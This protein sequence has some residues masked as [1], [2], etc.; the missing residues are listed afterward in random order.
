[1]L[2]LFSSPHGLGFMPSLAYASLKRRICMTKFIQKICV[3]ICVNLWIIFLCFS[4]NAQTKLTS[5]VLLIPLDDRPPCL[6]FPVKMGLIGDVEVVTPPRNL[7]GRFTE[8]GKSD[9]II[10]W[11]KTQNLK[12]FD[13]AIV[14]L[15][16]LSYGGLVA[17]REYET[18]ES[19]ALKRADFIRELRKS[20]PKM[21]IYGS[22]VIM[23]LAPTGNVVNESY[24]ANLAKWAEISV[25]ESK[26]AETLELEKKIPAE[27]L[28]KYKKA[29]QRDLKLN[30]YAVELARDRVIDYLILSQDDAKPNGV[31]V[32]DREQLIDYVKSNNLSEKVAV[33]PGA[34][35]VSMLLLARSM[36]TKYKYRPKIKAIYSDEKIADQFMPYEDRPLRKTVSFHIKAVGATEVTEEKDADILFYVFVSRFESGK[37]ENFV[38]EITKNIESDKRIILADVDPKG[39][40]QGADIRFTEEM[41]NL[42]FGRLAGY[43]SWNT[44]GNTIG[45]ALPHGIMFSSIQLK[46][47]FQKRN[48]SMYPKEVVQR[49]R[50]LS[51]VS[52]AQTWFLLNRLLDDYVYHSIVRP[53][54]ITFATDKTWNVFRFDSEQTKA[55]EEFS[56]PKI[57]E[58]IWQNLN[59]ISPIHIPFASQSVCEN[60]D[61]FS[62]TLPWGRTFEAEIDFKLSCKTLIQPKFKQKNNET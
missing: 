26:K 5:K 14:S 18:T 48:W 37:A 59:S 52:L 54:A 56:S 20:A 2:S 50:I 46:Y 17:M 40:I 34:D 49:K 60:V 44:A 51:R 24:R 16:M 9:E 47:G 22:S 62:F 12:S 25:D 42:G 13:A 57:K 8:F 45:T 43:A 53:K 41:R 6:Q 1:M 31:H 61:A 11:I 30:L 29:R 10:K 19:V 38:R 55:V 27:A 7:L 32:A 58:A 15:D 39:E 33:Q 3:F 28:E 36:T 23:R 35:E 21:P 4:A